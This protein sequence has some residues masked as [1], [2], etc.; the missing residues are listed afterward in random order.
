MG[1]HAQ[2]LKLVDSIG[3][4]SEAIKDLK[5]KVGMEQDLS[6]VVVYPQGSSDGRSFEFGSILGIQADSKWK[7]ISSQIGVIFP[8]LPVY[9][10]FFDL[11]ARRSIR[12]GPRTLAHEM[13]A[14]SAKSKHAP[15]G[16]LRTRRRDPL[17]DKDC[18][19]LSSD[20]Q[21]LIIGWA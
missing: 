20:E 16:G 10:R 5:G 7:E 4:L 14:L 19:L 8:Q 11:I 3:G 2:K 1:K 15:Q 13:S 21:S 17:F 9:C 12:N 18:L 6:D